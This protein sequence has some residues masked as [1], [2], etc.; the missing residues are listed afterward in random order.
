MSRIEA[1][2]ADYAENHQTSGNKICHRI[3]IPMIVFSLLGLLSL[4]SLGAIGGFRID[5]AIALIVVSQLFY[6][7]LE[8]RL[9][10]VML[11]VSA[12]MYWLSLFV[13]WPLHLALFILGWIL[14]FVGHSRYEKKMPKFLTNMVHLLVGPLW[15]LNDAIGVVRT[16]VP[17][18]SE[19]RG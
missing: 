8:P 18:P 13:P 1:L 14:Q 4:V 2:F 5:L 19:N 6:L 15:I 17:S 10:I 7:W 3:G 9:A 12:A 11:A 16:E